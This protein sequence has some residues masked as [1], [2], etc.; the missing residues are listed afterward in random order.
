MSIVIAISSGCRSREKSRTL[1]HD[2]VVAQFE[3]VF[4]ERADRLAAV[5]DADVDDHDV[6]APAENRLRRCGGKN[7]RAEDDECDANCA[8]HRRSPRISPSQ[9]ETKRLSALSNAVM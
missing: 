7:G 8:R 1:L 6:G 3:I 4:R 9:E 2:A 5:H